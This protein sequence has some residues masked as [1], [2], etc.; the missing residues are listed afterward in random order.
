MSLRVETYVP[1][2][3]FFDPNREKERLYIEHNGWEYPAEFSIGH[4]EDKKQWMDE[5][6]VN[7][8]EHEV[9]FNTP[10]GYSIHLSKDYSP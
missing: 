10:R 3:K 8:T 4:R 5:C 6:T 9:I 2:F 7:W 1:T